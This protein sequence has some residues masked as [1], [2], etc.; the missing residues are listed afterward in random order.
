MKP[1]RGE[2]A[3]EKSLK[4]TQVWFMRFKEG[5]SLCNIKMQGVATSADVGAAASY[6]EDLA[7]IIMKLATL[8]HRFSM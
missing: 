3:A 8:N 5:S 1:E 7:K 4:L 6:P 2:E